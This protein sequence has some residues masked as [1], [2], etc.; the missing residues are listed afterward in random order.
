MSWPYKKHS[1]ARK[2][3]SYDTDWTLNKLVRC[4]SAPSCSLLLGQ[5]PDAHL[6][7]TFFFGRGHVLQP[8]A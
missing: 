8:S 5:W 6:R 4:F 7:F 1:T 3:F 2:W